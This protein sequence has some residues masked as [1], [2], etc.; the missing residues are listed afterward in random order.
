[1]DVHKAGGGINFTVKCTRAATEDELTSLF[2]SRLDRMIA[3]GTTLVEA[4]S[5]YGL[6][7]ATEVKMMRVLKRG[8][9]VV[10]VCVT[11]SCI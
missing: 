4:K 8:Q 3:L 2:L 6:E 11:R 5:G 7:T 10:R 9:Y 1:M